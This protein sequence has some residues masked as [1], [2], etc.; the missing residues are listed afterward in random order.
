MRANRALVFGLALAAAGLVAGAAQAQV[1][2]ADVG[3]NP[4]Y[5]QTGPTTVTS[6][7][8]FFSARAFVTTSGDYTGGTLTYG[9]MGS[10]GT[11]TYNSSDVAWEFSDSNGSFPTL[12]GLY[13]TGGYTFDLT[14]GSQG[15]ASF[16]IDYVGNT[17]AAN[18]PELDAASFNALQ[19]MD[20]ATGLTLDFNSFI[21][22]GNPNNSDIVLTIYNASNTPVWDSGYLSSGETSVTIPGGILAAGQSYTFDLLFSEQIY[23]ENDS[24]VV[25]TTQFYD[26]HT[27]GAFFTAGVTPIPEPSTWAMM[28]VGFAGLGFMVRRRAVG[29]R[30]RA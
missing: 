2:R 20:A 9:G 24:P 4:T 15:P 22:T 21:T 16:T 11:L 17:Y 25:A 26:T 29:L 23:G 5:E 19:G 10:P 14:G 3:I 27:A 1:S 18:P 28:L 7:G 12:Q 8:G 6:T 30:A 13:P